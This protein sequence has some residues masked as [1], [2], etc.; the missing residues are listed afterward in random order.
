MRAFP[1][2]SILPYGQ[3]RRTPMW[4][5]VIGAFLFVVLLA[6]LNVG[7]WLVSEDPL[8][9]A[10]AIAVLSGRMPDRALEAARIYKQGYAPRVWLTHS[11]EPGATMEKLSVHYV[12]EDEYDKQ[13]LRHEGVPESAIEVLEPPIVNTADEM[14]TISEALRREKQGMV[15]L[16]TSK[17]HTRRTRALWNR[18][19]ARDGA[20]IVRGV[21]DDSFDAAHWWRNTTDALDVVREILGL[22]NAWAGL[23]LRPAT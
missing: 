3:A 9:K 10:T 8:Q 21:S 17:A 23:P 6:F 13:I 15:I 22:M 1:V 19:S 5:S 2:G 11:T 7:R 4:L 18:L 16:V 14:R 20:A 12:G